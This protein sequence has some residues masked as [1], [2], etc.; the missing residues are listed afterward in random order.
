MSS[1]ETDSTAPRAEH[2]VGAHQ[3]LVERGDVGHVQRRHHDPV[4]DVQ[5]GGQRLELFLPAGD[6]HQIRAARG[7]CAG[8][9]RT[10]AHRCAG[11]DN[12]G[13]GEI[14]IR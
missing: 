9:R 5:F 10:D 6:Q 12:G 7:K 11:E 8:R 4:A 3:H 14:G 2:L 13:S 1:A